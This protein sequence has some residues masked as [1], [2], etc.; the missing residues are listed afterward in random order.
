MDKNCTNFNDYLCA[1]MD[2]YLCAMNKVIAGQR[3]APGP[4]GPQGPQGPPGEGGG[5]CATEVT[6]EELMIMLDEGMLT[7]GCVYLIT[8]FQSIADRLFL[9]YYGF[10]MLTSFD[11]QYE[12]DIDPLLVT[13]RN[14][15][16]L[17]SWGV[18]VNT[19]HEVQYDPFSDA[20]GR[21]LRRIDR[22]LNIDLPMDWL[23]VQYRY[24][25]INA[26]GSIDAIYNVFNG[27]NDNGTSGF[28]RA[29]NGIYIGRREYGLQPVVLFGATGANAA[30]YNVNAHLGQYF[31]CAKANNIS[32]GQFDYQDITVNLAGN[33]DFTAPSPVTSGSWVPTLLT[34][35]GS[36]P[37][38][39]IASYNSSTYQIIG[40]VAWVQ[41][42]LTLIRN[43]NTS[44]TALLLLDET[45]LPAPMFI[46]PGQRAFG[47]AADPSAGFILVG[48]N[49][50]IA[51]SATWLGSD[52]IG[53]VKTI[54]FYMQYAI[55]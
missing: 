35:G 15:F 1:W 5:G 2:Y 42:E 34:G 49:T 29:T 43:D 41:A 33:N 17:V 50:S 3:G 53:E 45:T 22:R 44:S 14:E 38:W 36:N 24:S 11:G 19:G 10:T 13:A 52:S 55:F 18:S 20:K 54:K 48:Y 25:N 46:G 26:G 27:D 28:T 9:E 6:Y 47:D 21:I 32:K 8:D 30:H 16:S 37:D 39:S 31:I 7:A 12:G 23:A 4:A 40:N 51:I